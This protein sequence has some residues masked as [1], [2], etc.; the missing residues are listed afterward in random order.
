MGRMDKQVKEIKRYR[1]PVI[2]E[3]RHGDVTYSIGNIV[4]NINNFVW[5]QVVA[6]L[7]RGEHSDSAGSWLC[8]EPGRIA[9][10]MAHLQ[11][12]TNCP[13]VLCGSWGLLRA[14]SCQ[15]LIFVIRETVPWILSLG[16]GCASQP[17]MSLK[18]RVMLLSLL[19]SA[20]LRSGFL[21]QVSWIIQPTPSRCLLPPCVGISH[22]VS[23]FLT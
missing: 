2:K 13:F 7:P 17:S 9:T 18:L 4:D 3:I 20:G 16:I 6:I 22:L 5:W 19:C 1:L 15:L 23:E 21:T 10:E 8:T 14:E 11:F 12:Q